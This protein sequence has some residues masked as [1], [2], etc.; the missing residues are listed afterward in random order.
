MTKKL[1]LITAACG[2]AC[3]AHAQSSVTLYGVFDLA[4]RYT[5]NA[6]PNGQHLYS[7]DPGLMQGSR[8]GLRGTEALDGDLSVSFD[9]QSGFDPS[10]GRAAQQGQAWSRQAW[11][12]LNSKTLGS[13]TMGR[14]FGIGFD[15]MG[16]FDPYGI[17][18]HGAVS[19]QLD[20]VG[21]RFD[22]SV[23]YQGQ[24]GSFRVSAAY[25]PG[26]QSGSRAKGETTGL[27]LNY[28]GQGFTLVS[29]YQQ[30]T[31][32]N[33][34]K[35]TVWLLGGNAQLGA[36]KVFAGYTRNHRDKG[37]APCGANNATSASGVPAACISGSNPFG[38]NGALSNT[39]LRGGS[40]AGD[41]NTDLFM[42]GATY[43]LNEHV[44]LTAAANYD[45]NK[46]D[47]VAVNGKRKAYYAVADYYFSTRS[48]IYV[49]VDFNQRE[50]A[51]AGSYGGANNQLGLM[52]GMRHR[53]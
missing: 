42:L 29:A 15:T 21:A 12:A 51:L 45:N 24:F 4:A 28:V 20:A 16:Q 25:A 9:L 33:L 17:G 22:N 5:T 40:N 53:F 13:L 36:T 27:G 52:L 31:D 32:I 48:D 26:E 6:G 50:G 23:K 47:T 44:E 34:A 18:N 8:W 14:Q 3:A 2:F 41:S 49:S 30:S 19:W 39:N 38:I 46:V 35:S 43:R 11:V 37:F 1:L 10:T 7:V